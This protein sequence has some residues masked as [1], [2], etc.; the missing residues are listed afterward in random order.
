MAFLSLALYCLWQLALLSTDAALMQRSMVR[1]AETA[2]Y[3]ESI[4]SSAAYGITGYLKGGQDSIKLPEADRQMFN[5]R[6]MAHLSDVRSLVQAGLTLRWV[7]MVL[8]ILLALMYFLPQQGTLKNA[9]AKGTGFGIVCFY[10]AV[11]AVGVWAAMDFNSVFTVFH[12]VLFRNDLWL[13]DPNTDL[14]I[15]LMPESFFTSYAAEFLKRTAPFHISMIAL[16]AILL[17][18]HTK[19][20]NP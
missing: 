14:M 4:Y 2:Q 8:L 1:Y 5:D 7:L 15:R 19:E 3:D 6:E 9:A 17:R 11:F 16:S 12:K 18:I 13:L 10:P 20:E